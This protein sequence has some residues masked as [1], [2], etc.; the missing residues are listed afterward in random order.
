LKLQ[1]KNKVYSNLRIFKDS[2]NNEDIEIFDDDEEL[3]D[4]EIKIKVK[5]NEDDFNYNN[6]IG[7]IRNAVIREREDENYGLVGEAI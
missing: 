5:F 4:E 1:K 7:D 2:F 6:M 3:K